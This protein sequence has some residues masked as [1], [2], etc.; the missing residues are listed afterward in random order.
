MLVSPPLM[1]KPKTKKRPGKS[2]SVPNVHAGTGV[3]PRTPQSAFVQAE[4]AHSEL[5][6]VIAAVSMSVFFLLEPL[7]V[8]PSL[9]SLLGELASVPDR[10]TLFHQRFRHWARFM[11]PTTS[12]SLSAMESVYRDRTK[13]PVQTLQEATKALAVGRTLQDAATPSFYGAC[14]AAKE[15]LDFTELPHVR[16]CEIHDALGHS[17]SALAIIADALRPVNSM[18]ANA[19]TRSRNKHRGRGGQR[20]PQSESSSAS[21]LAA[22]RTRHKVTLTLSLNYCIGLLDLMPQQGFMNQELALGVKSMSVSED[23][24]P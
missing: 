15:V 8:S 4:L 18:P 5:R 22:I 11:S 12:F 14:R 23:P 24:R 16:A 1:A 17:A 13:N 2:H 3:A 6:V 21:Q 9:P 7:P 20:Q 19:N 10:S